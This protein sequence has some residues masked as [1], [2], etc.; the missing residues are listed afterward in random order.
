MAG[1][2]P[3]DVPNFTQA[4]LGGYQAGRAI[5]QQRRRDDALAMYQTDPDAGIQALFGV[6]PALAGQLRE[7]RDKQNRAQKERETYA[8]AFSSP[9]A[10]TAP[11]QPAMAPDATAAPAAPAQPAPMASGLQVNMDA[12]RELASMGPEGMQGAEAV[13]KLVQAGDEQRVKAF[14]N[15]AEMR[16]QLAG[17]LKTLPMEQR[18][19]AYEAALPELTARGF[20]PQAVQGMRFDDGML[21]RD[22]A[23]AVPTVKALEMARQV[24]RDR[25][26][27]ARQAAADSRA[28]AGL[29]IRREAL[30]IARNRATGGAGVATDNSDLAYLLDS[31]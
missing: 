29:G 4:A 6:D 3:V 11:M 27:D 5:G 12:I 24:E 16:G 7:N 9:A 17:Y 2:G 31:R 1:F 14:A 21:D 28:D 30:T 13:M 23:F 20:I 19:A 18:A 8:R 10:P 26:A 15:H 25:V 22:I